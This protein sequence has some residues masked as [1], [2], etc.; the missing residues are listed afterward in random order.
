MTA[1]LH[2]LHLEDSRVDAE[3]VRELLEA[4]GLEVE[5]ECVDGEDG[6]VAALARGHHDIILADYSLPRFDGISA[7]G[8]S[9]E[10]TSEL[11]SRP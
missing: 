10:H 4:G 9:E 2:I 3:L 6:F 7:L 5:V 11:Q 1:P 8:R